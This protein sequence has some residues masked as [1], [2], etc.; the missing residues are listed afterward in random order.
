MR[1]LIKARVL[2]DPNTMEVDPKNKLVVDMTATKMKKKVTTPLSVIGAFK[3][4][5]KKRP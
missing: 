5:L 3:M 2:E 1:G 4:G